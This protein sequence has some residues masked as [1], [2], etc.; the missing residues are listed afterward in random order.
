MTFLA[1]TVRPSVVIPD[2]R[3]LYK[4]VQV[5]LVLHLASYGKKS[6]MVRLQMFNWALKSNARRDKLAVAAQTG[7]LD[8]PA[9]GFDPALDTAVAL[10]KAD[11]LLEATTTGVKLTEKGAQLCIS[12]T[13]EE[14]YDDDRALLSKLKT[15]ITEKMVQTIVNRWV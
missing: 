7:E 5:L 13:E 15:S 8:F 6:S 1:F 2:H 10:G 3:P 12:A 4:I 14:L 11:G 9:W